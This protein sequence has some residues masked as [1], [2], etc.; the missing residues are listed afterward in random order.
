MTKRIFTYSMA[1]I[2]AMGLSPAPRSDVTAVP[3]TYLQTKALQMCTGIIINH[4]GQ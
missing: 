4:A 2:A 1:A 3:I